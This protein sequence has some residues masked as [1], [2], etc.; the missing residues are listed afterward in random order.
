MEI[1]NRYGPTAARVHG[2]PGRAVR[3]SSQTIDVHSHVAVPEEAQFVKPHL[4]FGSIPLVK[5]ATTDTRALNQRQDAERTS[6]MTKYDERLA[7]L[8]EMGID[9]QVLWQGLQRLALRHCGCFSRGAALLLFFL[10]PAQIPA[11]A[12]N[13][14]GSSLGFWRRSDATVEGAIP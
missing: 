7:D 9:L 4:D 1:W 8:E 3:P 13:P 11:G 12:A 6:R 10:L 14:P 5:F 2:K